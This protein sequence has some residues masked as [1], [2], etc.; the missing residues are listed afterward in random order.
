MS[1]TVDRRSTPW[2]RRERTRKAVST[3][4]L[5]AV[6]AG[7]FLW[8]RPASLGGPVTFVRVT[9]VSMEPGMSTGD[10]A[11]MR[12]DDSYDTGEVLAFRVPLEDGSSGP[13]VIHRV[14]DRHDGV[15]TMRGDN[16][17]F[18]D[19]WAV[20]DRDVA[21]QLWLHVPGVGSAIARIANPVVL[22][23]LAAAITVFLVLLRGPRE[24]RPADDGATTSRQKDPVS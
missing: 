10:L 2:W 9:G 11:V 15:L 13:F 22:A 18:D 3:A 1:T 21:G 17:D 6:L 5:I 14:K 19:P 24:T 8:L 16:N 23:A 7:W 20:R 4:L 12:A